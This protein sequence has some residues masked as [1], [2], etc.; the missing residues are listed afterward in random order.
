LEQLVTAIRAGTGNAEALASALVAFMSKVG[1]GFSPSA[2]GDALQQE[3]RDGCAQRRSGKPA[4]VQDVARC[5][6]AEPDHRGMA[7]ALRRLA[8][9]KAND[10]AF[11]DVEIDC[12]KEF[13]DAV[14]MGEFECA[15]A[16]IAELHR[17]RAHARP[18][19]PD[20]A[21]STIHKAKGLECAS[22]IVMPC[23]AKTF[24]D[25]PDAR[26]LLYVALS[27]AWSELLL[28][29]SRETPS[30]LLLL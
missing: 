26:C 30:P 24:P 15:D 1:K 27:R 6:V 8:D 21:I 14:R 13:Y 22:V 5:L 28:V 4:K 10:P 20:K 16:A 11:A 29:V 18:K 17:R 23:D 19:P 25:R 2:F 12:R 9:L 3:A 7:K